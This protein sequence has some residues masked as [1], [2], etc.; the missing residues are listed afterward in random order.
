M[1]ESSDIDIGLIKRTLNVLMSCLLCPPLLTA[2]GVAAEFDFWTVDLQEGNISSSK[3]DEMRFHH[4]KIVFP[5]VLSIKLSR[6]TQPIHI[7]LSSAESIMHDSMSDVYIRHTSPSAST[8]KDDSS[9]QYS[10]V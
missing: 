3:P 8:A 6:R 5:Q 7:R 10:V 9:S 1:Y 4:A 2:L